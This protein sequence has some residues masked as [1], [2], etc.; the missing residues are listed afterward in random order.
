M[1]HMSHIHKF[2]PRKVEDLNPLNLE[3]HTYY[4]VSVKFNGAN[5]EHR[6]IFHHRYDGHGIL[7]NASY[8]EH[9]DLYYLSLYKFEVIEEITAM[10]R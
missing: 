5:S 8:E 2:N 6:A 1:S 7:L 10:S 3:K 9:Y 4:V